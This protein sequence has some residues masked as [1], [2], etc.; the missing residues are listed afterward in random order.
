MNTSTK[1]AE[2]FVDEELA[3]NIDS[4]RAISQQHPH[5]T[6]HI[7]TEVLGLQPHTNAAQ[8]LGSEITW[9]LTNHAAPEQVKAI[10]QRLT[11]NEK[12]EPRD[13]HL[14]EQALLESIG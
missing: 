13:I 11:L 1:S 9:L 2:S 14:D 4:L 12:G 10:L 5:I 6:L 7:A 3:T 8:N